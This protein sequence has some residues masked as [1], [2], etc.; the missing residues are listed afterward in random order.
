MVWLVTM[1][2]EMSRFPSQASP[3]KELEG[4]EVQVEDG[5]DETEVEAE[6]QPQTKNNF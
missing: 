3:K 4:Q 1:A 2:T 5:Q 6:Q